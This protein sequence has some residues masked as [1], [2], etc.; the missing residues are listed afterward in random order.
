M[1]YDKAYWKQQKIARRI[2]FQKKI[3]RLFYEKLEMLFKKH[4]KIHVQNTECTFHSL[5]YGNMQS[6]SEYRNNLIPVCS[7]VRSTQEFQQ[8]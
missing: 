1:Y 6:S 3:L 4:D 7:F 8:S 2:N 5:K